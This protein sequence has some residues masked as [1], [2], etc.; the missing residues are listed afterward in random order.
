MKA[1]RE[2]FR[3][4]TLP[5]AGTV[6]ETESTMFGDVVTADTVTGFEA[7]MS[8]EDQEVLRG[9]RDLSSTFEPIQLGMV[10]V[11]FENTILILMQR[12]KQRLEE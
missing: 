11:I 2:Y 5:K 8:S 3:N 9:W 1:V 7:V 4:G 12:R 10:S 6:C